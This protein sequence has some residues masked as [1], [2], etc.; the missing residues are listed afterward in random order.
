MDIGGEFQHFAPEVNKENSES[1]L[2][3]TA[4]D[5]LS[6]CGG[7]LAR[8]HRNEHQAWIV[9]MQEIMLHPEAPRQAGERATR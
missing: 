5:Y 8:R 3:K 7:T 4:V 6:I 9:S 2:L 1:C